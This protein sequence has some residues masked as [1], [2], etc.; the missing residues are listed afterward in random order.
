[1][2]EPRDIVRHLSYEKEDLQDRIVSLV[3]YMGRSEFHS[4]SGV[5][6]ARIRVQLHHMREY[7]GVLR[8]RIE[9]FSLRDASNPVPPAQSRD[10]MPYPIGEIL[11]YSDGP[12]ALF[13]VESVNHS[14]DPSRCRYYG[15]QCLGGVVGA[16][17]KDC[18]P[19]DNNDLAMWFGRES[20]R[21]PHVPYDEFA[22]ATYNSEVARGIVHTEAYNRTMQI[23][24]AEFN[25][26]RSQEN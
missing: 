17:H 13:R 15:T 10:F 7:M 1:M 12:T 14:D 11:R 25:R 4:L 19:P 3:S 23:M 20:C 22:L 8:E 5:E 26:R 16:Y 21:A 6:Q 18:V 24:Q 9:S 2:T